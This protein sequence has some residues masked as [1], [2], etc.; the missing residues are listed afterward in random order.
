MNKHKPQVGDVWRLYE[1]STNDESPHADF[2]LINESEQTYYSDLVFT[3]IVIK[4]FYTNSRKLKETFS[5]TVPIG[6]CWKYICRFN[7]YQTNRNIYDDLR[8]MLCN[9]S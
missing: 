6:E 8:D 2:H 1:H 3:S 9:K 4:A 7:D 5:S